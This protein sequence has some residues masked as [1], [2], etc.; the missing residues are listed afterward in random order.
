[1]SENLIHVSVAQEIQ[2]LAELADAQCSD[3][4]HEILNSSSSY[5]GPGAVTIF[6][7]VVPQNGAFIMTGLDIE[8]V[9]LI[10][11]AAFVGG[12]YRSTNDLNPFGPQ[13]AGS[14][15]SGTIVIKDNGEGIFTVANAMGVINA[16]LLFV[17]SGGHTITILVN[18]QQP[19]A[20]TLTSV[21]RITGYLVPESIGTELKKK[22]S[23]INTGVGATGIINL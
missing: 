15:G 1:M 11:D 17:F 18:P 20:K 21:N 8:M 3:F 4:Q 23:R 7:I 12:D 6:T 5:P 13:F 10:S 9:P 19:A 14:G 2:A 16:P 22:E